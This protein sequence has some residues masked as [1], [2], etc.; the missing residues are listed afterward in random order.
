VPYLNLLVGEGYRLDHSPLVIAQ[1]RG[2]EGFSLHGGNVDAR[3]RHVPQLQYTC[4]HGDIVNSLVAVS[5]QLT[6]AGSGDGGFCVVRGSHKMSFPPSE[7][8]MSGLD[9]EFLETCVEQPETRAGDVVIFSEATVHGALPWTAEHQRRIALYRFAP[10]NLAFARGYAEGWP[11][12]HTEG[13]T[14]A[15]LAVM[16]KPFH[17]TYDRSVLRVDADGQ[18]QVV[19]NARSEAKK[20]FD[21]LV[22]GTTYF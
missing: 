18:V 5:F 6:D 9:S 11:E 4:A 2:S 14:P 8:M 19:V 16:Q 17:P 10:A 12:S 1:E 22:F 20:S 21:R 3:G 15:Q 7:A 13:M